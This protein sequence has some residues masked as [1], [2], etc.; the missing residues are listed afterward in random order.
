MLDA[1]KSDNPADYIKGF[2]M[3]PHRGIETITYLLEGRVDHGDSLGNRDTLRD[4]DLQWMTA[5][6]GILHE[7]MPKATKMLNGLQFWLNLPA[8]DK[9]TKPGYFP[10]SPDMVKNID[11]EGGRIKLIAGE[12]MGEKGVE[13]N[14]V[15]ATMMDVQ[16]AGDVT[17][18]IPVPALENSFAYILDGAAYFGEE[19][20]PVQQYSAAIFT[21]GDTVRIRATS[22]GVRLVLLAGQPLGEPVAWG[23]P[24]VMNT[25]EELQE[26]FWELRQG[27]FIK[28]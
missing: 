3:H 19:G 15:K 23:G 10:I 28:K 26:A 7:E 12:Y 9:M 2:P 6:S 20:A 27:T 22:L 25:D 16:L 14:Y 5:G 4:G 24:I 1:F 18:D 8:K 11:V 17:F 21:K 13:P